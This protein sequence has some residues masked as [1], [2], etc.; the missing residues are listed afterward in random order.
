MLVVDGV[1]ARYGAVVAL[2]AVSV[3][4]AEGELVALV[5]PNG[6]GKTT[7]LNTSPVSSARAAAAS[8]ST[9]STSPG[10]EP[11]RLVRA[12]LALVPE[13][14]R[15]FR[16][17]T[18]GENL[19]LAGVTARP[20]DR[21]RRLDEVRQ[22]FTVLADRWATAAGYLSGGEAQQLAVARALMSDPRIILLDEPTLGLAP[23]MVDVV[24]D[25]LG[26]TAR[27]R[28][29]RVRR[30]AERQAGAG[31]RRPW[32]R[33]AHRPDRHRGP[34][35]RAGRPRGP[36][37]ALHRRPGGRVST[38]IQNLVDGIGRGSTYALLALG[39]SL[40]FGVMHLVNFAHAELITVGAY[41]AYFLS[42]RGLGWWVLAPAIVLAAVV[43]SVTTE[44][45]AFRWVRGASPFTLLLTSFALEQLS[46]AV[47][48]IF[49]SPSPQ[50]F[51]GPGWVFDTVE[52]AGIRLEVMDLVTIGV[53]GV[54]LVATAY[55]FR[56]T[57]FGISVRA[58]SEDFDAARLMGVR[59]NRVISG[60]FAFAGLL[61]GVAAVLILMRS[62]SAEP[63]LGSD[64]LIKAVVAAIIGG[65][66]SFTG[67]VVGGLALGVAEVVLRGYLPEGVWERMTD[68][69]VFVLIAALFVIRPQ[70][71]FTVRSAERV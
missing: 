3:T 52:I 1:T 62:P 56:R 57:L 35:S 16:D 24:F 67:A 63:T 25:L 12:G 49:V 66:G 40:I 15:I 6:A 37:R 13:R 21:R 68:A 44:R 58:A 61:A 7:L 51:P 38:L 60:A 55:V 11:A 70:G 5:G 27:P 26:R 54:V 69:F 59:A 14:R 43:A 32:L 42:T 9:A 41:V 20:G 50:S 33:A 45:V 53:T 48:A 65:L 28:P 29:H 18:V 10:A 36:L 17:L 19:Q 47:W 8:S 64:Y 71:L 23:I 4:V 30:R 46:H 2:H 22:R 39:I 34:R 31:D